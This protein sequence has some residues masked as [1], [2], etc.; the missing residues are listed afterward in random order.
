M[1]YYLKSKDLLR[2]R[3]TN[4]RRLLNLIVVRK[5]VTASL[6][7]LLGAIGMSAPAQVFA[8]GDE[9]FRHK[10]T[11]VATG[12]ER[13]RQASLWVMEVQ[14]KQMRLIWVDMPDAKTKEVKPELFYYLCYRAINRPIEAPAMR[15]T[16]PRNRKEP[17]PGPTFF[18]PEFTL[19][20]T[21]SDKQQ[22][23]L[24]TI[25]PR[26]VKEINR[27]ER[28]QY[29]NSVTVVGAVPEPTTDKI[30]DDNSIYGVAVFRGIDPQ[31]DRFTIYMNGF[32]NGYQV[33]KGPDGSPL[34]MRKTILQK[35]WRPGDKFD[36][37]SLEIGF[38]GEPTWM[39]RPDATPATK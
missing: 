7:M 33:S 26:V 9:G 17:E 32:S 14:L 28:R 27:K 3:P 35:V 2:V 16:E 25:V 8:Q 39:F 24:D 38:I 20:P 18:I 36:V 21:D 5:T 34:V 12:V 23:F 37:E 22:V 30:N 19:V 15:E 13:Y 29:K 31:V 6:A 10:I 1:A 4:M 11:P